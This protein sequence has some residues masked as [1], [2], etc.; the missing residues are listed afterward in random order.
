MERERASGAVT[1]GLFDPYHL[2]LRG[3]RLSFKLTKK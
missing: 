1:A 2:G 3:D